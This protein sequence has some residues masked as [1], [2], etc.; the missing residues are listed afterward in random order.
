MALNSI[1]KIGTSWHRM[2]P[3]TLFR[4]YSLYEPDYLEV[5][6][7]KIPVY[8]TL[9]VQIKGYDF[10][11][12]E[13]YQRFIHKLADNM[14]LQILDSWAVPPKELIVKRLKP[15][16]SIVCA[17]YNLKVYKRNTQ[18]ENVPTTLYQILLRIMEA[19]LP[20]GVT[21]N[22]EYFDPEKAKK[23]YVPD[24]ELLDLK[25]ELDTYKKK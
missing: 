20:H 24:K 19:T 17:E 21:F 11:L 23:K 16:S 10:P 3:V 14:N 22:I 15:H 12:V 25:T 8:P 13:N 2:S 7:S 5:G 4:F 18:I 9:N 6:K 1:R